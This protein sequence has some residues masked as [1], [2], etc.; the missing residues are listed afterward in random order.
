MLFKRDG[1]L[2]FLRANDVG[3][4]KANSSVYRGRVISIK[5]GSRSAPRLRPFVILLMEFLGFTEYGNIMRNT[6][7]APTKIFAVRE[8]GRDRERE[9]ER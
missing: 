4:R 6:I 5:T 1:H 2:L 9:D 3:S 7:P 8:G